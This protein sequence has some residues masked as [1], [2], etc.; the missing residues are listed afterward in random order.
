MPAAEFQN[1]AVAV[2]AELGIV[3]SGRVINARM[4]HAA[5]AAGLMRRQPRFFFKQ[6]D[7]R[8][9]IAAPKSHRGGQ[10]HD[11]APN[12][13]E[14]VRRHA[15]SFG[16]DA[17]RIPGRTALLTSTPSRGLFPRSRALRENSFL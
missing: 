2:L 13:R 16:R 1:G 5:V 8:L 12:H 14:V 4:N 10:P 17:R 9:G 15:C 3:A 11:A 7:V 6:Q